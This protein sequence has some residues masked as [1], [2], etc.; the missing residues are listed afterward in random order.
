M[1]TPLE[2]RNKKEGP[3]HFAIF[4]LF[5]HPVFAT[6]SRWPKFSVQMKSSVLNP[7]TPIPTWQEPRRGRSHESRRCGRPSHS[8]TPPSILPAYQDQNH[9]K[10]LDRSVNTPALKSHTVTPKSAFARQ[11]LKMGAWAQHPRHRTSQQ[12]LRKLPHKSLFYFCKRHRELH[13]F[14]LVLILPEITSARDTGN[15][16]N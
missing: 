5:G 11:V 1:S 9:G 14:T 10:L 2:F 16:I 6:H 13:K 8:H 4:S 3:C 7:R 12:N 15:F